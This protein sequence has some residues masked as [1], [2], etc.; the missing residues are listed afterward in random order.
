MVHKM[1]DRPGENADFHSV[2]HVGVYRPRG[3]PQHSNL[4]GPLLKP[5]G[6]KAEL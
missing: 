4:D 2:Q 6:K 3:Q 1:V 5:D